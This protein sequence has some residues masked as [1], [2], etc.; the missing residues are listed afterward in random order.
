[1]LPR[2]DSATAGAGAGAPE[3]PP[4][5]E[6]LR[7]RA[8]REWLIGEFEA[9][10]FDDQ[11]RGFAAFRAEFLVT[12]LSD[13]GMR[14]LE[15]GPQEREAWLQHASCVAEMARFQ[16]SAYNVAC[17]GV[18]AGDDGR[19]PACVA[20]FHVQSHPIS[21]LSHRF[22]AVLLLPCSSSS[23]L[24]P[25]LV[26]VIQMAAPPRAVAAGLQRWL[27][28]VGLYCIFVALCWQTAE[29]D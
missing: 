29:L 4:L 7:R 20:C 3:P 22:Q 6:D 1:M 23:I 2:C 24:L 5:T 9:R 25:F 8:F 13:W 17:E 12:L 18:R 26:G 10:A 11:E 16:R 14:G 15:P 19:S 28:S 27:H 21:V